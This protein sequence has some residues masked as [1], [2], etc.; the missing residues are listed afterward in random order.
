MFIPLIPFIDDADD[1][2]V[3][4]LPHA[5]ARSK[6]ERTATDFI[7]FVIC[8]ILLERICR[9]QSVRRFRRPAPF[10]PARC[11]GATPKRSYFMNAVGRLFATALFG[12][13][14]T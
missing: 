9:E 1:M 6:T 12:E 3:S 5:A 11:N 8:K 14:L 7:I 13:F 10:A 4:V 2:L